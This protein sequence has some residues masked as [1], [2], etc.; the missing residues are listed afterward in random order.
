MLETFSGAHA[1]TG[2]RRWD[3]LAARPGHDR[4]THHEVAVDLH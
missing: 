1:E 4:V 2:K 3:A